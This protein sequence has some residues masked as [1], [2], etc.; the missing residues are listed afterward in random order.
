MFEGKLLKYLISKW[1]TSKIILV[2]KY[3]IFWITSHKVKKKIITK[4]TNLKLFKQL[5]NKL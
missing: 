5:Q 3:K 4:N 2:L 1:N